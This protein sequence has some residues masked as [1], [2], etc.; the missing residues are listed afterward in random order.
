MN[1]ITNQRLDRMWRRAY[2]GDV[3][4]INRDMKHLRWLYVKGL[5]SFGQYDMD[6]SRMKTH[7]SML[8]FAA[9]STSRSIIAR[10]KAVEAEVER[11]T[12]LNKVCRVE[13]A[14]K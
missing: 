11:Q 8:I 14:F 4:A 1:Q 3:E 13:E 9:N 5:K 7:R 2:W 10:R 12:L 6:M